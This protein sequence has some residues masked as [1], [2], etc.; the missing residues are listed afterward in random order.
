M[1]YRYHH[2]GMLSADADSAIDFYVENFA[3]KPGPTAELPVLGTVKFARSTTDVPLGL[4][5]KPLHQL[6]K[7]LSAKGIGVGYMAFEVDD[8]AAAVAELTAQDCTLAWDTTTTDA[9]ISAGVFCG[10]YD[11][12]VVLIQPNAEL[13]SQLSPVGKISALRFNHIA[14]VTRDLGGV[15]HMFKELFGLKVLAEWVEHGAGEVKIVDP[16]YNDTDHYF[17]VEVLNPPMVAESDLEVLERRGTTWHHLSYIADDLDSAYADLVAKG[18][19]RGEDPVYYPHLGAGTSFLW[20]ADSNAIE[21][22]RYDDESV[23]SPALLA[24]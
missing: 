5:E 19:T 23:I 11:L 20:D 1:K 6:P 14:V 3:H 12:M 8:V 4:V 9:G 10:L 18:V 16:D 22:Y 24:G 21:V 15:I 2:V 17:L 13:Q 7:K